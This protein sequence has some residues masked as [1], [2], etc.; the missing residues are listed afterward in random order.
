[1]LVTWSLFTTWA[2]LNVLDL[3]LGFVATQFGAIEVG[4]LYQVLGSWLSVAIN[5]IV[6]ALLI[7]GALVYFR[8]NSWL[9]MLS[10]GMAGICIYQVFVILWQIEVGG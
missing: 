10:I 3:R 5:K 7:G 8:K 4:L 6:L 9:A 1:M 2:M